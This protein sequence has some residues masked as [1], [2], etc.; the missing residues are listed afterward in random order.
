MFLPGC[1][2]RVAR[3]LPGN[4]PRCPKHVVAKKR[5]H[6]I[7]GQNGPVEKFTALTATIFVNIYEKVLSQKRSHR[8][9]G[10]N[11]PIERSTALAGTIFANISVFMS[12]GNFRGAFRVGWAGC[13]FARIG[14]RSLCRDTFFCPDARIHLPG[15]CPD[16]IHQSEKP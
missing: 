2:D 12:R 10:Q 13:P 11:G 9:S 16:T 15:Y 6:R 14:Q 4:P 5:S 3:I 7:S 1:P 8:N